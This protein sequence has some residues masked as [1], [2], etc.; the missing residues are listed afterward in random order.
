MI[1]HMIRRMVI[2]QAL[3]I[4]MNKETNRSYA[5]QGYGY[6]CFNVKKKELKSGMIQADFVRIGLCQKEEIAIEW[7]NGGNVELLIIDNGV[8]IG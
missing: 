7:V 3:F 2:Q 8:A 5:M 6:G 4:N 1:E